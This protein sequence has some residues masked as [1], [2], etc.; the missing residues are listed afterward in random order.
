MVKKDDI[1]CD[2]ALSDFSVWGVA[3]MLTAASRFHSLHLLGMWAVVDTLKLFFDFRCH[4]D[5]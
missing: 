5:L 4:R 1:F 2:V 3:S